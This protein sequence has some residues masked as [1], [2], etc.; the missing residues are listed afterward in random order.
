MPTREAHAALKA[1]IHDK[2]TRFGVSGPGREWLLRCL[3]PASEDKA[4][5]IPDES[6]TAV[7]RPDFRVQATIQ[8]P[9]GASSWDCMIWTPPGDVNA[10]YWATGPAGVNFGDPTAPGGCEIGV[11]RLQQ[12]TQ[13][14]VSVNFTNV[15]GGGNVDCL[16]ESASIANAGFRHQFKSITVHQIASAVSDQGQVYAAQFAPMMRRVSLYIPVGY[17]SGVPNPRAPGTNFGLFGEL[18]ETVLPTNEAD[19]SA[20]A[21]DFYMG[22]SRE[23]VYIPLRL[24]GPNQEFAKAHSHSAAFNGAGPAYIA[25]ASYQFALGALFGANTAALSTGG[26][27]G[28][29]WPFSAVALDGL[30]GPGRSPLT[31]PGGIMLDSGFDNINIGVVIFRGL[32]GNGGG[33]SSSLQL[34]CIAGLEIAPAPGASD[35]VFAERAA[36]YDPKALEAYYSLAME[37]QGVYPASFNGWGDIWDAIKSAASSVWRV[38]AP[39]VEK[40][41]PAVVDAAAAAASRALSQMVMS[42]GL[43]GARRGILPP[44]RAQTRVLYRAP[45]MARSVTRSVAPTP[46]RKARLRKKRA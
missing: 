42:G 21:P 15:V 5:G 33:F 11:L 16:T 30:R 36:A 3:H 38:V 7:L 27:V 20:M 26:P 37:L 35:R 23:G 31:I 46:S 17:D 40:A 19:L 45:S 41:A 18:V 22:P 43:T 29:P 8:A 10:V 39:A 1:Q 12:A 32:Q 25:N 44:E 2:L 34:K 28:D 24:A 6:N 9:P 13:S 4:P 14:T